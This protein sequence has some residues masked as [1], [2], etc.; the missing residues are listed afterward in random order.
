MNEFKMMCFLER[1]FLKR[2]E[3][4]GFRVRM[5]FYLW[6]E[7]NFL[8]IWELLLRLMLIYIESMRYCLED[9]SNIMKYL[10]KFKRW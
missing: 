8:W 7:R 6:G 5:W 4:G 3:K 2:Y 1:K 9:G 10:S